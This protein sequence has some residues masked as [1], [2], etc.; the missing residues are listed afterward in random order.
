[1]T[2]K[3]KLITKAIRDLQQT[4]RDLSAAFQRNRD[5]IA[6]LQQSDA[7]ETRP[8]PRLRPRKATRARR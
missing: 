7:R 3:P 4:N 6:E 1:M 8:D 2:P 5:L